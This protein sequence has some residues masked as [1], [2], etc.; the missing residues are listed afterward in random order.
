MASQEM[1]L[2]FCIL[3][4]ANIEA[5]VYGVAEAFYGLPIRKQLQTEIA[6]HMK[7]ELHLQMYCEKVS[8]LIPS[9]GRVFSK[10][11]H[12]CEMEVAIGEVSDA[13]IWNACFSIYINL[14]WVELIQFH[15]KQQQKSDS[16]L[17]FVARNISKE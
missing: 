5:L 17:I 11:F 2:Q 1:V 6:K 13:N 12:N 10:T 16:K 8:K 3:S 14:V 15:C 4:L 7:S 9:L